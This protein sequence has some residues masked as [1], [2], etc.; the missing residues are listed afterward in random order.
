M[1]RRIRLQAAGSILLVTLLVLLAVEIAG[2]PESA[3][4]RA[5]ECGIRRA[6]PGPY[7]IRVMRGDVSCRIAGRIL[8]RYGRSDAPC[9][10]SACVRDHAGWTCATAAA[11]FAPRLWSCNRG[12]RSIAAYSIAD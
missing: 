10:G 11:A 4:A 8:A 7:A 1:H 5:R 12:R 3:S 6:D 9:Q 2:V